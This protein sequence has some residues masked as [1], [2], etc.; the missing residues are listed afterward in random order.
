MAQRF[1]VGAVVKG[2]PPFAVPQAP[3]TGMIGAM[4]EALWM[5]PRLQTAVALLP[6][7][8]KRICGALAC[9]PVAERSTA[10]VAQVAALPLMAAV[11]LCTISKPASLRRIQTAAALVPSD[12]RVTCDALAF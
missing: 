3:F 10:G 11:A 2:P 9:C 8:D 12:D 7:P 6:S 1:S 4:A 5:T